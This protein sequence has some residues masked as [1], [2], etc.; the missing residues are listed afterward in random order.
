MGAR[1]LASW[2]QHPLTQYTPIRLQSVLS[3]YATKFP[4][5]IHF[6]FYMSWHQALI[7]KIASPVVPYNL[8]HHYLRFGEKCCLHLQNSSPSDHTPPLQFQITRSTVY[9]KLRRAYI[10]LAI[11]KTCASFLMEEFNTNLVI[12]IRVLVLLTSPLLSTI[13]FQSYVLLKDTS[14]P[15]FNAIS[16]E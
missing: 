7:W 16:H 5:R 12:F 11:W 2:E 10:K 8:I 14:R 3:D 9:G 6:A 1:A 13:P 15:K 4:V